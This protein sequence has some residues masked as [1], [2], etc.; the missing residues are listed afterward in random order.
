M[1]L[2][3]GLPSH[4]RRLGRRTF[5][6]LGGLGLL[7]KQPSAAP[8]SVPPALP[9]S[10]RAGSQAAHGGLQSPIVNRQSSMIFDAHLHCP[11]AK[12]DVWQ[13]HKVTPTFEAF[14]AY[15]D[16]TGVGRGIINS[17]RCQEAKTPA[18]FIAGNREVARYVEKY[19]GR[20]LG[21]CVVNP[22]F[23]DESLREIEECRK[24]FGFVW[25]G[26]LCN[27]TV[28]YEYTIKNFELLVEQVTRLNMVLDVH[29]EQEEMA[30]IIEKF[31]KATIVFPH[32]GDDREYANIF[33]RIDLVA[34]HPNCYLD[35]SGY[36]HDRVG[37]LEYAVKTIGP[38]RVLFGSDFSINDPSTVIARIQ[39][40]FLSEEE[41]KKVLAS[42]LMALLKRVGV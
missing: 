17:V 20:F 22:L 26:E 19:K 33:K 5:V 34:R 15:L 7:R 16:R 37:M 30:Y 21:A 39:N 35:T 40:S 24:Q 32:F 6:F 31:P 9:V 41:K 28:P 4:T 18:E 29:T 23:I 14:V 11:S 10:R 13:W 27:Y 36:G 25:V 42:N 1:S 38:D 12:G 8:L 3:H 2:F